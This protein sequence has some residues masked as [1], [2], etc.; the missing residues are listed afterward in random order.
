MQFTV[1]PAVRADTNPFILSEKCSPPLMSRHPLM[2]GRWWRRESIKLWLHRYRARCSASTWWRVLISS[3]CFG[4]FDTAPVIDCFISHQGHIGTCGSADLNL[5]SGQRRQPSLWSLYACGQRP[6]E[7]YLIGSCW[8]DCGDNKLSD[9]TLGGLESSRFSVALIHARPWGRRDGKDRNTGRLALVELLSASDLSLHTLAPKLYFPRPKREAHKD[10]LTMFLL[11]FPP[12]LNSTPFS[13]SFSLAADYDVHSLL[14][15]WLR[16]ASNQRPALHRYSPRTT[17]EH[18]TAFF[19]YPQQW[20]ASSFVVWLPADSRQTKTWPVI[21]EWVSQH[22]SYWQTW[23]RAWEFGLLF[24]KFFSFHQST[25]NLV[26]PIE[27]K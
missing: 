8:E 17:A 7:P 11:H 12:E 27:W 1:W 26:P 5:C 2:G 13:L 14:S 19:F 23:I 18:S 3:V 25:M 4:R 9:W 20:P 24:N 22:N 15:A 21:L 6:T 10:N 16:L